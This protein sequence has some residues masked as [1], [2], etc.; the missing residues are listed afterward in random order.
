MQLAQLRISMEHQSQKILE[1]AK[2][3]QTSVRESKQN[4]VV[5]M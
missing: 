5:I 3:L 4:G 2:T 1:L